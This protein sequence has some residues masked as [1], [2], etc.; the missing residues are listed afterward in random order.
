MQIQLNRS[1]W[2]AVSRADL[3]GPEEPCILDR[4]RDPPQ[5]GAILGVVRPIEKHWESLLWCMQ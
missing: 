3:H 2:D 5:E 1:D 4:D